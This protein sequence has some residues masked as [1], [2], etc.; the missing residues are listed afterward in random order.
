ML[1]RYR[2]IRSYLITLF[3]LIL[4]NSSRVQAISY[5]GDRDNPYPTDFLVPLARVF[6]LFLLI[7]GAALV[8]VILYGAIKLSMSFGDPRKMMAAKSVLTY[9]L[10]GFFIIVAFFILTAFVAGALG[11]PFF[12]GPDA[13]FQ[14]IADGIE[15]FLVEAKVFK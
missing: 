12:S 7:A 6:N 5:Q 2:H 3:I 10:F 14:A 15:A 1:H 13:I 9:A 11:I 8:L 4:I